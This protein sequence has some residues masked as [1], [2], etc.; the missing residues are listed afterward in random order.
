MKLFDQFLSLFGEPKPKPIAKTGRVIDMTRTT[1]GHNFSM[2][3]EVDGYRTAFLWCTPGPKAG[4]QIKWKTNYGFA[5]LDIVESE[6]T[7]NVDDMYKVKL[8]V[9]ERIL[10]E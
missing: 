10:S 4:D 5:I 8:V 7:V 2:I 3:G 1:W 6:W 9:A